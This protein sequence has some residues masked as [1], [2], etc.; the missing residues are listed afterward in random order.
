MKTLSNNLVLFASK[1]TKNIRVVLFILTL[2][3]FVL[4]A[5]APAATGSVGG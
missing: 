5:G 3:L 2:V 4:A 1:L